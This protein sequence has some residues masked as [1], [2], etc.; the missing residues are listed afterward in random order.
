[1]ADQ[2]ETIAAD[3]Q[4]LYEHALSVSVSC[5]EHRHCYTTVE[6]EIRPN[7]GYSYTYDPDEFG[8]AEIRETCIR[9]NRLVSVQVYPHTPVGFVIFHGL[10]LQE[11]LTRAR[12]GIEKELGHG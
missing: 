12:K 5:N 7:K 3:L 8:S 10:E 4:W 6:E 9:E 11:V 2:K 1:M